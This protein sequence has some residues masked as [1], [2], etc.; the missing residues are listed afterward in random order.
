MVLS[1]EIQYTYCPECAGTLHRVVGPPVSHVCSKCGLV[2]HLDPKVACAGL[3]IRDQAVLLLKRARMPS[4]GFWC[5]PGGFVDRG[6][7]LEAAVV[8]EVAE[9]T[10]LLTRVRRLYG[11]YSYPGYSVV[12]AIYEVDEEG[13]RF[14]INPENTDADWF[15]ADRIPW[16]RLA[17][18]SATDALMSRF[19]TETKA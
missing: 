1:K 16:D 15:T 14:A 9:E 3:V 2:I 5:L 11:L 8:R 19:R 4:K 13:G 18:P 10:G 12:V 6:E 17:F 7:T